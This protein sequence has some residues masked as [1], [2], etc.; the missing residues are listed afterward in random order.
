MGQ[1][2][3]SQLLEEERS[4][5]IRKGCFLD[6][7]H[8]EKVQRTLSRDAHLWDKK[9][10]WTL[11][12]SGNIGDLTLCVTERDPMSSSMV[13][14]DIPGTYGQ[15]RMYGKGFSL[16]QNPYLEEKRRKEIEVFESPLDKEAVHR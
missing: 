3:L 4:A 13:V 15:H 12:Q 2:I 5:R 14:F 6:D 1:D 8:A 9:V 10:S 7:T 11:H 16:P